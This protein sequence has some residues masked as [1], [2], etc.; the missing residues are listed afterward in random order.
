MHVLVCPA[1]HYRALRAGPGCGGCMVQRTHRHIARSNPGADGIV[2]P[3]HGRCG[4][5]VAIGGLR[6]LAAGREVPVRAG[7]IAQPGRIHTALEAARIKASCR[8]VKVGVVHIV[9]I[10]FDG[11]LMYASPQKRDNGDALSAERLVTLPK[12]VVKSW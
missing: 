9:W 10:N 2:R 6:H 1:T 3:R 8:L 5:R 7:H 4:R 12:G 11:F